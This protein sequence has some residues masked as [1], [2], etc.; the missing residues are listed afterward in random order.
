MPDTAP[1]FA[2]IQKNS[3]PEDSLQ[4]NKPEAKTW[5]GF[6]KKIEQKF[7]FMFALFSK[8]C[9]KKEND[10]EIIIELKNCSSF[11]K[12]RIKNK[13]NGLAAICKE[14]LGKDLKIKIVSQ[15]NKLTQNNNNENK[16]RQAAFNHPMVVEAQ[17]MFNG[18]I[19]N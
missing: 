15:N 19:I 1:V 9:T 11:D 2:P 5:Q 18:E 14:F 12:D 4:Q 8:E 17:Q 7:P 13:K 16:K 3:L 10:E 6:L